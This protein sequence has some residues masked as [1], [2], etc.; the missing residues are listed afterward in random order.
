M[1]AKRSK[2]RAARAMRRKS[3][4]G[5][6]PIIATIL[7]VAIT[8][9][10]AAVLY[11]LVSGLTRTG[12]TTPYTLGM[13][14]STQGGSGATWNDVIALAPSSGLTTSAFGLKVITP[15]STNFQ[16]EAAS[17]TGCSI[18]ATTNSPSSCTGTSGGWYA[19]L[20]SPSTGYIVALWSGTT[21]GWTY[22]TGVT[23]VAL[24]NGYTLWIIT[25]IQVAGNDYTLS[26]YSTGSSSVSG[27]TLL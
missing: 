11:V 18:S 20:V 17:G 19:V 2:V 15:S 9:V 13:T 8:V 25:A 4:R 21:P 22:P 23:T 10:L 7:L 12:A 5:V 6:S 16:P 3:K 14:P 26:A 27:S 1:N 24:N